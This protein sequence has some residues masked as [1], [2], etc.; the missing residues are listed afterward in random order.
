[1]ALLAGRAGATTPALVVEH[2]V[3]WTARIVDSAQAPSGQ[4]VVVVA[5]ATIPHGWHVYSLTQPSGG[6]FRMTMVIGPA[7]L[8]RLSGRIR[9][10]AA[11]VA[12]DPNFGI[13]TETYEGV[14]T[15]QLP[16]TIGPADAKAVRQLDVD[17]R[18]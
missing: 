8:A 18:L 10:P 12:D 2:P 7:A 15:F 1:M 5:T 6:P 3:V 14:A 9:G 16:V 4:S 17:C 11:I 13:Q